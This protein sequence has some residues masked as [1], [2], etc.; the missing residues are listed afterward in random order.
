MSN[1]SFEL[2]PLLSS[3]EPLRLGDRLTIPRYGSLTVE[4]SLLLQQ[5]YESL[6]EPDGLSLTIGLA[7]L[8]LM[9]RV[10]RDWTP[11]QTCKLPIDWVERAAEFLL[12]EQ[13]RWGTQKQEGEERPKKQ[14]T[15]MQSFGDSNNSIQGIPDLDAEPLASALSV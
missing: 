11:E 10:D 12:N 9:C 7:T 4:E 8:L 13:T 14:P 1:I 15:G 6:N 3:G 5:Y 2:S